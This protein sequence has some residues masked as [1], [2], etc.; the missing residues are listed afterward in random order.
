MPE[1]AVAES[2]PNSSLSQYPA[3]LDPGTFDPVSGL[4]APRP[5]TDHLITEDDTPVDNLPSEKEQRLLTEPLYSS[6]P[7]PGPGRTFLVAANV[8]LFR[9]AHQQAIVP[10]VF[11]SL[12][13]QVAEDWWAHHNRAY[14]IWEFGKPPEVVI[15]IVSNTRGNELGSKL[16]DYA[17][18]GVSY[19]V[20]FDPSRKL[21]GDILRI[22]GLR[23]GEYVPL[24]ESWLPGVG[25]G[26][27][28]WECMFEGRADV[29]LRWCDQ[30]GVLIPTGAERAEQE[31]QRAEQAD[32]R[33]EQADQRAEQERQRAEQADQRAEQER[34]RAEQLLAQLRALGV[35]PRDS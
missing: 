25:L 34:Q 8:G 21:K 6:W 22:Y 5:N 19:Y 9:S 31:R 20:V 2:Q 30:E 24:L 14:F 11:L 32:Q 15:E 18:A 17:L 23:E 13:V 27:R 26:L 1:H 28:L 7:G 33:A 16:R 29:W 35:E 4:F 12:D 3:D 10:D